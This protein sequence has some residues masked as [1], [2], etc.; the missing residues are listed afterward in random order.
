[1]GYFEFLLLIHI[2]GA[3]IG[4]GPTYAFS[5]LG[6]VSA[7]LEPPQ[8]IGILKGMIAISRR[9]VIPVSAFFQPVSGVLL[10]FESGRNQN[11]FEHEW[12]WISI[13]LYVI[14]FYLAVLVQRPNVERIV[15]LAEGGAAGTEEFQ[16]RVSRA[17]KLGPV[18]TV[19]L[20][21][22]VFL[23]ITKPGAPEGFF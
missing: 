2:A 5:V 16:G 7:K 23:M 17:R 22:I 6:P 10:I 21:I 4:F 18:I 20:T 8:R 19:S 9:L 14:T 15:A 3:I 11:F 13:L 12:L 1:M